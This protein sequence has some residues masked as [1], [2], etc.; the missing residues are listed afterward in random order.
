VLERLKNEQKAD[1]LFLSLL[2]RFTKQGRNVCDKKGTTYAPAIFADE[3]E[4]RRA[5]LTKKL[6]A[7]A[8]A[9]L[10]VR[11]KLMVLTEGPRSKPRTRIVEIEGKP[12]YSTNPSTNPSTNVPPPSTN[13]STPPPLIPP[14]DGG[15]GEG[16][17]GSPPLPPSSSEGNG[18][19]DVGSLVQLGPVLEAWRAAIGV[20]EPRTLN[21]I[22]ELAAD[23]PTLKAALLAVAAMDDGLTISNVRL[24]RWL[25]SLNEVPVDHL[26]LSGGGVDATGSPVWTLADA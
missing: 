10:F 23:C 15:R 21:Q 2:R 19:R 11:E 6:L 26:M 7:E 18:A 1:D 13:P 3:P 4:A 20:G 12:S 25:R 16:L 14:L 5:K 9:R 24:A 17:G 22:I 8:M